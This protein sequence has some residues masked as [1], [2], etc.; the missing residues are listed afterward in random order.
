MYSL[1]NNDVDRLLNVQEREVATALDSVQVPHCDYADDIA[2][3]AC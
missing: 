3:C 1:Y 2:P